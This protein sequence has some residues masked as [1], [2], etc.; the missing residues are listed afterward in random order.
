MRTNRPCPRR[1]LSTTRRS[2]L[3][4]AL[5][6]CM[7]GV[8]AGP[9]HIGSANS[10][11]VG[12]N[13]KQTQSAQFRELPISTGTNPLPGIFNFLSPVFQSPTTITTY[14]GDCTTAKSVYNLQD[15]DLTVC[16]K[17][18]GATSNQQILWSNAKFV[19][20][21]SNTVGTDTSFTFTLS[22][23]SSLGDWRVILFEPFGGSVYAVTPFTVIDAANPEADLSISKGAASET[24]AAGSQAVF[25]VQVTNLGPTDAT[26]VQ[27]TDG[28]PFN[29]T[30][31]SFAAISAPAGTN[32]VLPSVGASSGQ[33]ICTIPTLARGETASFLAA[34][35]TVSGATEISNTASVASTQPA[36]TDPPAVPDP[37]IDNNSST[38]TVLIQG[39]TAE[40]C[41]L[42]CPDNIVVTANTTQG[43]QPGAFVTY[44]AA[45]PSGN[46]GA[47]SNSPASGS[48]FTVG[49]HS[50]ISQ[51]ELN[52]ASCTFTVTVLDSNPP[53]ITC[54]AN[55]VVTAPTGQ[56]E[57]TVDPG[58][59][60]INASGGGTV[61]GIRSDDDADPV[62]PPKPL[63]D[64]YPL[65]TT[66]I[67]W[68][69]TDAGGRTASC[70]QTITVTANNR[71]PV[72]I[73]C[74]ANVSVA[75]PSGQCSTTISAATIGTPTTN[76]SDSDVVVVADR[77]DSL[78]LTDPFPAGNTIITWTATDNQTGSV[79]SCNQ[80]IS[81]TAGSG[82]DTTPPVL[83]VPANVNATTSSCTAVLDDELGTAS[84]TDTGACGGSVT[85]TRT[86]VPANFIFPTG[87][88]TILYTATD[89]AGNQSTG[90]QLVTV[91]ES[92]AVLPTITAPPNVTAYT[93]PGAT[94]C[95]T[96]VTDATLGTPTA[97]D[98]CSLAS[99][100]RTGVPA[101]N[102]FPVGTTIVTYRA[103]DASGNFREATQ[104]V[105]VID[106]TVPVVTPPAA[107]T[108]FT[109][110]GAT[111]CGVTVSN[112]NATLGTGSATD[113]CPGVGA[114]SRSG[115]PAGNVFPVGQTTLTY[116][117]TDAAGNTGSATQVVTV[118]DNT[119]PQISC[120][121]SIT[122]EP[123]CPTGAIATWTPPV[124]TDNCAGA[125]TTRTAGPAPGS[126]FSIG[127]TT[128]TYSVTDAHGNGPVSCSFTVTVKTPQ[129]VIQDLQA[130]VG[131]SSLTGT[132]KN[133][134]LAKLSAALQAINSGQTNV[135]CN[136]LSEFIN[137][138]QNLV[139][140][141]SLTSTTGNA[142][143]SSANHV[144]NTIG[145][146]NLPCS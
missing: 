70:D 139:S 92:P 39:T 32:C 69:V 66:G 15:T 42:D 138:V 59:P 28:I 4:L 10:N 73:T 97:A 94:S 46:C 68:T 105:T 132:Q 58:T 119:P 72:S 11:S 85:V 93:G 50:V 55:Q 128:V 36:P 63:T 112:L 106:N 122:L 64:P 30:F 123:T 29:S 47:V 91:T 137:N 17:V 101:G 134:L 143:I 90:V 127:T 38:A 48:F 114:V 5:L 62:T 98:N 136:K 6:I 53:T 142:W 76:P 71:P 13:I 45:A 60:T 7:V 77:S 78:A 51:S 81:V 19:L 130:Q 41:T 120:P 49:L 118:V 33:S 87:T 67:H 140:Q 75:A 113:N 133:G 65:G 141:G 23:T 14:A 52:A 8:I 104:A 35:D 146:T 83:T 125:V 34:Y 117:A 103:T 82:S 110:A 129:A 16:A 108:L 56:N 22:P 111:S 57:A 135:A 88:T 86:G 26:N 124:G 3:L 95:G 84:A 27:I 40:T 54:P 89:A 21:Q 74:P 145:C 102:V 115:V 116:S 20:V 25:T 79:A 109:G 31:S 44:G 43:G 1:F 96:V 24:I 126:V 61:T 107:V 99:V 9:L 37:N 2:T 80:T 144:R 121:A 100:T 12:D 18:T 131:A